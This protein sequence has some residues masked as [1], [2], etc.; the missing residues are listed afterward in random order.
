M[1]PGFPFLRFAKDSFVA[2]SAIF[3]TSPPT[4]DNHTQFLT[5]VM[6]YVIVLQYK[7]I[8]VTY[9]PYRESDGPH[10]KIFNY[11]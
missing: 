5:V 3:P 4:V 10:T 2:S 7:S 9:I 6:Y 11:S 8:I 1:S